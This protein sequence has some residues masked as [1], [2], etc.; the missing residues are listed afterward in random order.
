MATKCSKAWLEIGEFDKV[1]R[2]F[3][4]A[5]EDINTLRNYLNDPSAGKN[6]LF[7]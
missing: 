3:L 4:K 7:F 5:Q 2:N 6:C 1:E